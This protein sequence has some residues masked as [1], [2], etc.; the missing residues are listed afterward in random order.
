[1]GAQAGPS[2]LLKAK[3]AKGKA[4]KPIN[5]GKIKKTTEKQRLAELEK[6]ATEFVSSLCPDSPAA[7]RTYR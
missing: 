3:K 6:A 4:K 5:A 7:D 1:M 2:N